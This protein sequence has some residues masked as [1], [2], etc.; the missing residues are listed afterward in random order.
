MRIVSENQAILE[1]IKVKTFN[2]AYALESIFLE[3][4]DICEQNGKLY[5][6]LRAK[7]IY[8]PISKVE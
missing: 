6:Y 4:C 5:V 7:N 8:L 3:R 1:P 2:A